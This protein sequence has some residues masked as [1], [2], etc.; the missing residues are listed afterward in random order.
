VVDTFCYGFADKEANIPLREDHI[1]RMFSNTK[2]ITSCAALLLWEEGHFQLDDPLEKY[3]PALGQRQVLRSH[4]T[5][6]DDCEPVHMSITIR[7]LM[8]HT[9][10]FTNNTF[11]PSQVLPMAYSSA[12]LR[13]PA[14]TTQEFVAALAPLPLLYQPGTR[15]DYSVSTDVLAHL[16]EVISGEGYRAFIQK[17]ILEPLGMVDTDYFVNA[18][19]VKRLSAL[20]VG[21]DK[22][23]PSKLGLLRADATPYPGAF[24]KRNAFESGGGGMVSTLGDTV[25]LMQ[26]MLTGSPTLLKPETI[27]MMATNQLPQAMQMHI[28]TMPSFAGRGFGLGSSVA[29]SAAPDEPNEVVGEVS[30]GGLGGT[31]WWFNPRLNIAAVLMTSRFYSPWGAHTKIFRQEAYKALGYV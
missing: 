6:L 8:T 18:S 24:L 22:L 25:H 17:R 27:R 20:Y 4:A 29:L 7:Q 16:V 21:V 23:D 30:W 2:L 9:G 19:N 13:N 14:Q 12:K 31:E 11:N 3:I 15:W 26:S 1:F 28:D 10:G 5:D